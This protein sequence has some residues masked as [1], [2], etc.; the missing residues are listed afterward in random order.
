LAG[1]T[2]NLRVRSIIGRFLEH[3]RVFH[4][5]NGH[6]D[7]LDGDFY[8]GSADWMDRNLSRRVEAVAPVENRH[9]REQ[10]WEVLQ[11]HLADQ[12]NAWLMQPDG[13]YVQQR[14]NS[15]APRVAREG[16]HVT[17]MKRTRTRLR[18]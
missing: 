6:E 8:L 16:S 4:F 9:L 14:P 10:L 1:F 7:P 18:R 5:A 2:E 17:L 15:R 3:G 12:R 13:S 11:V